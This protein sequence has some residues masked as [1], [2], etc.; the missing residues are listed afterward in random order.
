MGLEFVK[1]GGLYLPS[2][3]LL[4]KRLIGHVANKVLPDSGCMAWMRWWRKAAVCA[5]SVP[6][7]L[8]NTGAVRGAWMVVA[9]RGKGVTDASRGWRAEPTEQVGGGQ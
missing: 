1:G 5:L 8:V 4:W 7:R 2:Q 9:A 3:T 6:V